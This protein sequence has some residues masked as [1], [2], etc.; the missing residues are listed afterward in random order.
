MAPTASAEPSP[1]DCPSGYF[2]AWSGPNQT[3]QLVVKTAGD[4][5]GTELIQSIFNNGYPYPGA[6]HVDVTINYNGY[7]DTF[8]VHHNPGPGQYKG[9]HAFYTAIIAVK[10][11]GECPYLRKQ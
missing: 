7:R 9:N 6:D 3:G 8:C 11:R 2:C 4:W 1:P 5:T 10:W